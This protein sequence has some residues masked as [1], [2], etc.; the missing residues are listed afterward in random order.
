MEALI[1]EL[2]AEL[3]LERGLADATIRA[4]LADL[5]RFVAAMRGHGLD[6]APERIDATVIASFL[7]DCRQAG[8]TTASVARQLVVIK[9]FFRFLVRRGVVEKDV[10]DGMRGARLHRIL[11]DMLSVAEVQ[12]LLEAFG[13]RDPLEAR[14][15]TLLEVFY[16]SGLRVSELANLRM[17]HIRRDEAMLRVIGKGDKERLVP[18]GETALAALDWYLGEVRPKLDKTGI[19]PEVFL[20]VRGKPLT[21]ARLWSIVKEAALRAGIRANVYPHMLRH[22]FATHMLERGA[23]LRVIQELL[24]H[25]DIATT[26]VYTHVDQARFTNL[27]RQF[28]PRG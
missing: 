18:V 26:Q 17:E 1:E 3:A 9:L 23:D 10:T 20:S 7:G 12:A 2:A 15:R 11:P 5:Q 24:G 22:S 13:T 6:G 21:R 8:L 14:N 25:A 27:H 16:A 28:H 19:H 4:Y